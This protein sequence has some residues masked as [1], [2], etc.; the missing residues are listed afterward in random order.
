MTAQGLVGVFSF[1]TGGTL[2]SVL[3]F[4]ALFTKGTPLL[5]IAFAFIGFVLVGVGLWLIVQD[6]KPEAKQNPSYSRV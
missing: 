1:A 2:L 6:K 3:F 5:W 4:M